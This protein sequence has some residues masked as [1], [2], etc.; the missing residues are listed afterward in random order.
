MDSDDLEYHND[1]EQNEIA[2][3]KVNPVNERLEK[4]LRNFEEKISKCKNELEQTK[5]LTNYAL[6]QFSLM[7]VVD[8]TTS[9]SENDVRRIFKT[10]L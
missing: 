9:E 5:V 6:E 3:I 10:F 7:N 4:E 8:S 2:E 1:V